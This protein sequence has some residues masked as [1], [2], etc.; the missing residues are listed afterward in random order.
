M[1]ARKSLRSFSTGT[2]ARP[3]ARA[4][5]RVRAEAEEKAPTSEATIFYGGKSYTETEVRTAPSPLITSDNLPR[6]P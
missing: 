4:V 3:A 5:F 1:I 6:S 2:A